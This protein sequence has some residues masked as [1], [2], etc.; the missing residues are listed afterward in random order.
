M[1]TSGCGKEGSKRSQEQH[2]RRRML[3]KDQTRDHNYFREDKLATEENRGQKEPMGSIN[4]GA[5]E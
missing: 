3:V 1:K 2:I 5:S 4:C